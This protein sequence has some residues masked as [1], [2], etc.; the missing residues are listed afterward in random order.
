[1]MVRMQQHTVPHPHGYEVGRKQLPVARPHM[2]EYPDEYNSSGHDFSSDHQNRIRAGMDIVS[3][4]PRNK[5]R[6][7]LSHSRSIDELP[8]HCI[9]RRKG[10]LLPVLLLTSTIRKPA[11]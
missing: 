5:P 11:G 7:R 9:T 3:S 2:Q 8:C 10:R 6:P 1:M 4:D